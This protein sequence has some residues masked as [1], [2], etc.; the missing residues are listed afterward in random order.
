M[1][2]QEERRDAFAEVEI[3]Q[4]NARRIIHLHAKV[5]TG[6][7]AN[8]IPIRIYRRMYPA[9]LAADGFPR[10]GHLTPTQSVL[11]AYNGTRIDQYGTITLPCRRGPM[12]WENTVFH[13]CEADGPAITGLPTCVQ[14]KLVTLNCSVES[15][16]APPAP[17]SKPITSVNDLKV[18]YPEQFDGIGD[19]PGDYHIVLREGAQP[20]VHP[21]RKC[22]IHIRDELKAELENMEQLGVIRRVTQPTDW[23]N[24]IAISR[25]ANGQLRICLDP[26]GL[27]SQ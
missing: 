8:T 16:A 11:T 22:S 13:V 3:R 2:S 14:L 12:E 25:K 27:N 24:S 23:V 17:R 21:P 20:V 10:A 26:K 15:N 18:Q 1:L 7:Q 9:Q 19:F 6:A 4:D 5:D